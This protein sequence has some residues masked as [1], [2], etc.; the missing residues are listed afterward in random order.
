[1]LTDPA[2]LTSAERQARTLR[3]YPREL[4]AALGAL[5]DDRALTAGLGET[6]VADY[7]TLKRSEI[8]AI[9]ALGDG[10]EEQAYKFRF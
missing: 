3:P 9:D 5:E 6:R 4:G 1:M 8:A 10:G 7:I 2:L